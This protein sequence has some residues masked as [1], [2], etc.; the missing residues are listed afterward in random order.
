M[1][2]WFDGSIGLMV[3]PPKKNGGKREVRNEEKTSEPSWREG[4][5]ETLMFPH[6]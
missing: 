3:G 2:H 5:W 1:F 4:A 6:V